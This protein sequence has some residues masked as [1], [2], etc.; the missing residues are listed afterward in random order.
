MF[1]KNTIKA[2]SI[3]DELKLNLKI[4]FEFSYCGKIALNL[5]NMIVPIE[6]K[7]YL[8]DIE[9]NPHIVGVVCLPEFV[10]AIDDSIGIITSENPKECLNIIQSHVS[11][12]ANFQWESF[13]SK[14]HNSAE[15]HPS[16]CIW[17][18]DVVIGKNVKI[19]PNSVVY[20][21]SIIEDNVSI[22][23]CS[24]I[25][26]DAYENNVGDDGL[27]E[28]GQS[29][30]VLLKN[31]SRIFSNACIVRATYGG[32]TEIGENSM[33]DNLVHIAHDVIIGKNVKVIACAEISG[34][35]SVGDNSTIG[36][37]ATVLNGISIG[38]ESD[39]S[40]GSVVTR[41]VDDGKRVTGNFAISHDEFISNLRKNKNN[42]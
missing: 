7:K 26:C 3:S 13:N 14:I 2:S 6:A 36:M 32:F 30:G 31:A 24:V 33:I 35:V 25:G 29:G 8:N 15:I 18:E 12:L 19:G 21:R 40:L 16:A 38:K 41:N 39:V 23:A 11:N 34:R 42:S 28:F 27:K 37:N 5:P 1:T 4:D 17:D 22:G 10:D 9:K 20:P